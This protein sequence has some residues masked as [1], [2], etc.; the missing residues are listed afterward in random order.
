MLY[1]S[2]DGNNIPKIEVPAVVQPDMIPDDEAAVAE[3]L[4]AARKQMDEF[5]ALMQPIKDQQKGFLNEADALMK[6]AREFERKAKQAESAMFDAQR[7]VRRIEQTIE[8]ADRKAHR[9]RALR[10]FQEQAASLESEFDNITAGA[11]WREWAKDHQI[12]GMKHL[13]RAGRCILADAPR[14]GKTMT[15]LGA[16]DMLKSRRVLILTPNTVTNEFYKQVKKWAPHR[17]VVINLAGKSKVQRNADMKVLS[18]LQ[19]FVVICNYEAWRKDFALLDAFVETK[20]DTVII[21]E[22]HNINNAKTSVFKGIEKVVFAENL[23]DEAQPCEICG[24]PV[25]WTQEPATNFSP[26]RRWAWIDGFQG[27]GDSHCLLNDEWPNKH[28]A[29]KTSVK[30]VFPMTGTVIVNKPQDLWALLN[31]V[32]RRNFPD[33]HFFER[34]YLQHSWVGDRKMWVF[35]PGGLDRLT[36]KLA[37]KYI[38]RDRLNSP[39]IDIPTPEITTR[40]LVMDQADYPAQYKVIRDLNQAIIDYAEDKKIGIDYAITLILRKR[41]AI[42]WPH[43]ELKDPDGDVM[44]TFQVDESIKIDECIRFQNGEKNEWL[45]MIP[46]LIESGEKV[47]LA[48]QF[49]GT[50]AE[51]EQR[52]KAAGIAVTNLGTIDVNKR[53]EAAD[54]FNRSEVPGLMLG[55][56]KVMG[57]GIN[58]AGANEII[59]LDESWN[60][61]TADQM[62]D[63]IVEMGKETKCQVTILRVMN[64]IDTWMANLIQQ[65]RDMA[66]GFTEKMDTASALLAEIKSGLL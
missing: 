7:A 36:R 21:D 5:K 28:Q 25:V 55:H 30:H 45:G 16:I 37:D 42:T 49:V 17:A 1:E 40:T 59:I 56:Y 23:T 3:I 14:F 9:L 63:R 66:D 38:R 29:S 8:A 2:S 65:K 4:A 61:A 33:R 39:E 19:D 52:A 51:I 12:K 54:A 50:L 22:A 26:Y 57:T 20:F 11:P 47:V 24:T 31:L 60:A 46:E 34:D 32:D 27:S 10:R 62:Y 41:Q 13:A 64:S 53:V 48:S 43:F 44:L 18:Y 15:V 6:Q 58:L 35:K